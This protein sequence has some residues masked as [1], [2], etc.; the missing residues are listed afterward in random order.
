MKAFF[1]AVRFLTIAPVPT[2]WAGGEEELARSVPFFPAVGLL[3]GVVAGALA[4][5][6]I[7]VL[8]PLPACVLVL[9]ALVAAS[10]ALHMDGLSDTAD[11]FFS[12]RPRERILEIMRDSRTGAMGVIAIVSVLLLKFAALASLPPSAWWRAVLIAA[13]AG[14]CSLVFMMML[15]P[16][17]R[18][19]GGLG[20][21]FYRKRP[22]FASLV[23]LVMLAGTAWFALRLAGM[24]ATGAAVLMTLLFAAQCKRKIGG[25]TGD[26][27]GAACELSEVATL[28]T[29]AACCHC[30][31]G[32]AW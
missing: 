8:P 27:L 26:T 29:L 1:A 7:Q 14:R 11:G 22:A 24:V 25:A 15:L 28:L 13:V 21:V 31:W 9:I 30:Q 17:V 2:S 20:S 10:G 5:D 18:P 12:S 32:Y 3:I 4:I 16:Y 23:A 6:L 19:E